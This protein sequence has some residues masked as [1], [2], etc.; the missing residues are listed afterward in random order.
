MVDNKFK[1]FKKEDI[2]E[3]GINDDVINEFLNKMLELDIIEPKA[4]KSSETYQFSNNL[5]YT[6]FWIKPLKKVFS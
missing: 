1:S 5:Y 4:R 6:Y 2:S 3:R